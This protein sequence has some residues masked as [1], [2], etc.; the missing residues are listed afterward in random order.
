MKRLIYFDK[1]FLR[2]P[3]FTDEQAYHLGM[4]RRLNAVLHTSGVADGLDVVRKSDSEI[5]V[6]SGIAIDTAGREIVLDADQTLDLGTQLQPNAKV[7][8]A[9]AYTETPD[10][11]GEDEG[12]SSRMTEAAEIT[13]AAAAPKG[14]VVL[15]T[16]TATGD[17]KIPT[18]ALG[19]DAR[20]I[21]SAKLAPATV[22]AKELGRGAVTSDALGQKAVTDAALADGAVKRPAL[23]AGIITEAHLDPALAGRITSTAAVEA[24]AASQQRLTRALHT[25]GIVEGLTVVKDD[26]LSKQTVTI[27]PGVAIDALGRELVLTEPTQRSTAHDGTYSIGIFRNAT[28]VAEIYADRQAPAPEA[29]V[30]LLARY[31]T[32]CT[33]PGP[34]SQM[35]VVPGNVGDEFDG[36]VRVMAGAR[37][38]RIPGGAGRANA[39]WRVTQVC[40]QQY[41][42]NT[43]E[44]LPEWPFTSTGGTLLLFASGSGTSAIPNNTIGM[45]IIIDDVARATATVYVKVPDQRQAFVVN[46]LVVTDVPAGTHKAAISRRDTNTLMNSTDRVTLTILELPF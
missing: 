24:L 25:P 44:K 27:S 34:R 26:S 37:V 18:T 8:V 22:G 14:S 30:V 1:Q 12:G 16:F 29:N 4:R 5:T 20:Q 3:D 10:P 31:K 39:A 43:V 40:D 45:H 17:R 13:V 7:V 15:A 19:G 9:I 36:G 35:C 21:A 28:G 23:G 41:P 6:A 33:N 38:T 32:L 11:A 2:E 46:G 42:N